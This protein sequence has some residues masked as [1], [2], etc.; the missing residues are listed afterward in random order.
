[1]PTSWWRWEEIE[2]IQCT[3]QQQKKKVKNKSNDS[4]D[5]LPTTGTLVIHPSNYISHFYSTKTS[6]G[7]ELYY[8]PSQPRPSRSGVR[9]W[10]LYTLPSNSRS[11]LTRWVS[12]MYI[13]WNRRNRLRCWWSLM[14]WEESVV[15]WAREITEPSFETLRS[16][17]SHFYTTNKKFPVPQE[18][19][20]L[21]D[22]TS[23]KNDSHATH[24]LDDTFLNPHVD[25]IQQLGEMVTQLKRVGGKELGL[26]VFDKHLL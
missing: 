22:I 5:K 1:M 10:T 19:L 4:V 13:L 3:Q 12:W 20:E 23:E 16:F 21:H 7:D 11:K 15:F 26:H 2:I 24:Y 14:N 9:P 17:L 18:L 6:V 8:R 25:A